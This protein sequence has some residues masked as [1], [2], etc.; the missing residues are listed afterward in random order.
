MTAILLKVVLSAINQSLLRGELKCFVQCHLG[1]ILDQSNIYMTTII[2]IK[3]NNTS[4]FVESATAD[5]ITE[6][7]L[8]IKH[9]MST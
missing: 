6:C 5:V 1:H 8:C 2:Y 4:N 7:I 3:L 9:F